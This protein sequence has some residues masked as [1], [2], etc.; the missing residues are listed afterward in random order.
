MNILKNTLRALKDLSPYLVAI[1]GVVLGAFVVTLMLG[2]LDLNVVQSIGLNGTTAETE[3]STI[4]QNGADSVY[5]IAAIV[6]I[7]TGLMSLATIVSA[8]GFNKMDRFKIS[9]NNLVKIMRDV[10][11]VTGIY[12]G[13][14]FLLAIFRILF[15]FLEEKI[16]GSLGFGG[17]DWVLT[18][19]NAI[20]TLLVDAINLI[21]PILDLG[22][23]LITLAIVVSAF[24]FK[25]AFEFGS[26]K[27]GY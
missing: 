23:G 11:A 19:A 22:V 26:K 14:V 4:V 13:L 6:L 3:A 5:N 2:Y 21:S 8:F 1:F 25:I 7:S 15:G 12:G 16:I 9:S 24:G 17:G 10:G 27:K 20:V 18:S